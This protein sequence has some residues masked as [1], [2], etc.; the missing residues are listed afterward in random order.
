MKNDENKTKSF[1]EGESTIE[2]MVH[3]LKGDDQ[4]IHF[5][6]A[7][8]KAIGKSE[9]ETPYDFDPFAKVNRHIKN[10]RT[11]LTRRISIAASIAA[12]TILISVA[13]VRTNREPTQ[14]TQLTKKELIQLNKNTAKTLYYFSREMNKNLKQLE[15]VN[16]LEKP[17]KSMRTLSE[18]NIEN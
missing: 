11:K 7:Y 12:L 6:K 15:D 2:D 18:T 13:L 14:Y 16:L 1:L 17:L 9:D 5:L 4:S 8:Q 10:S 3:H